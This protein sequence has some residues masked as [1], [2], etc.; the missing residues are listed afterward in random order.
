MFNGGVVGMRDVFFRTL[1]MVALVFVELVMMVGNRFSR[2]RRY[3]GFDDSSYRHLGMGFLRLRDGDRRVGEFVVM[4]FVVIVVMLVMTM[5]VIFVL[6]VMAIGVDP[7]TFV[8][9]M[10]RGLVQAVLMPGMV[11]IAMLVVTVPVV[12]VSVG[13]AVL[14]MA[15][16]G[17][18]GGVRGLSVGMLD[19][20]A[21]DAIVMAAP[22]RRAVARTAPAGTVLVLFLGFAM[23]A[24]VGLDQGLT[25]GDR[26]LVIVGMD[27]AEGQEAV[28][29]TAIF[30]KGGL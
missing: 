7:M 1:L 15:V 4:I 29:V 13:L 12:I 21:L 11:M 30:D 3:R 18:G 14:R 16:T 22:A 8:V 9:M 28:A 24:F 19:N 25:V 20:P 23:G 6:V 17:E 5:I 27:F 10:D 26:D 2:L